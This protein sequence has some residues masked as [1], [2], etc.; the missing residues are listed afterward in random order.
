MK[1]WLSDLYQGYDFGDNKMNKRMGPDNG[2]LRAKMSGYIPSTL[3]ICLRFYGQYNRHGD[4]LGLIDLYTPCDYKWPVYNLVCTSTGW[5]GTEFYG[6]LFYLDDYPKVNLLRKWNSW[7]VG[8]DYINDKTISYFNGKEVNA[9]A[10]EEYRNE[11]GNA[12]SSRL[13]VGY[14]SGLIFIILIQ[15]Y[16]YTVI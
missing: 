12:L 11:S 8:L 15:L 14:F 13:P 9:T 16:Y 3:T 7:C 2:I 1:I 5:C 10:L 6:A 4:Q